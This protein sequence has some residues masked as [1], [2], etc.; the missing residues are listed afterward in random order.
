MAAA[1]P[2]LLD[3]AGIPTSS[4]PDLRNLIRRILFGE[5]IVKFIKKKMPFL[6]LDPTLTLQPVQHSKIPQKET[7]IVDLVQLKVSLHPS[8]FI[9]VALRD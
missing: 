6:V 2:V 9:A 3:Q 5:L 8:P 4:M 7:K 1:M